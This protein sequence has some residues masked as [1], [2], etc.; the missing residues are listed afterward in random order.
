MRLSQDT[1]SSEGH[2]MLILP[3]PY[4]LGAPVP[5]SK[6]TSRLYDFLIWSV[7]SLICKMRIIKHQ[8]LAA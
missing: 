5:G 2:C 7:T 4:V 1:A 8:L 6:V 3:P